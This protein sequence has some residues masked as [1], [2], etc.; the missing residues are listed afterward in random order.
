MKSVAMGRVNRHIAAWALLL[1]TIFAPATSGGASTTATVPVVIRVSPVAEI[2]FPDGFNFFI[3]VPENKHDSIRPVLLPFKIR[4]NARA[5]VTVRPD[6]FLRVKNGPWLGK[7]VR[8]SSNQHHH[9]WDD[10][11]RHWLDWGFHN[12]DWGH[13]DRY[14]YD[15]DDD[16]DDHHYGGHDRDDDRHDN[17]HG[18]GHS[19]HGNG[20]G[21]G[22]HDDDCDEHGGGYTG[23]T[24]LGYNVIV[25]FPV[26]S[27]S[28][29]AIPSWSGY[30]TGIFRPGYYAS[31]PGLNNAGTPI[32]TANVANKPHG[33]FG[34][35][36]II[37]KRNWTTDG[38]DA[39]PG[40]YR[41][42]LIV[43]V[44]ADD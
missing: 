3:L 29:V 26:T 10:W 33:V 30:G 13:H 38:R 41:G 32:L 19:S 43:T 6:A 8:V 4:G 17:T 18:N 36:Y 27:L 22:H 1:I 5:S 34:L 9:D 21:Y 2:K 31:L 44:T 28:Q 20:N 35:I 11:D 40:K 23:P 16:C 25:R 37:S 42:A 39:Q 14:G 15:H 12:W 7:A 24:N